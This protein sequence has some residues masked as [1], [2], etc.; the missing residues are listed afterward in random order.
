MILSPHA[1]KPGG[2]PVDTNGIAWIC[3]SDDIGFK[4]F[5]I[6]KVDNRYLFIFPD[7]GR[8]HQ[9]RADSNRPLVI[10]IRIG[11]RCPMDFGFQYFYHGRFPPLSYL[12][13]TKY[14]LRKN[15]IFNNHRKAIIIGTMGLK[16]I[17]AA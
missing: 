7:I 13:F 16:S 11:N 4:S 3:S 6:M 15:S 5:P 10:Q 14:S 1:G 12:F 9:L 17:I 8:F 2:G